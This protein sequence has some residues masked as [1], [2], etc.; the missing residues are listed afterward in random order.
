M[1]IHFRLSQPPPAPV[2]FISKHSCHPEYKIV[3]LPFL[4]SSHFLL[5]FFSSSCALRQWLSGPLHF[6][7]LIYLLFVVCL[8]SQGY[9][10]QPSY[11]GDELTCTIKNLHKSTKYKFRV[12]EHHIVLQSKQT[13]I[14]FLFIYLCIYFLGVSERH[15]RGR[16][17]DGENAEAHS[18]PMTH[19][20]AGFGQQEGCG[21]NISAGIERGR[22]CLHA[23]WQREVCHWCWHGWL[24]WRSCC[25]PL[26]SEVIL[27][28]NSDFAVILCC[29]ANCW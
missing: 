14:C 29:S 12:R 13:T 3:P 18:R 8:A 24:R 27:R 16:A 2:I 20:F 28:V 7:S 25:F 26:H 9:G 21:Q 10:F 19:L 22:C 23:A 4:P 11:D 15:D 5:K 17:S 1:L 6:Y